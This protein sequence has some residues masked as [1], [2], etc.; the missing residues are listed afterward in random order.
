MTETPCN[1]SDDLVYTSFS[2]EPIIHP[3]VLNRQSRTGPYT[4][5]VAGLPKGGTS[6]VAAVLD[7][8]GLYMGPPDKGGTFED[9][10]FASLD[11]CRDAI[12]RRNRRHDAWGFKNPAGDLVVEQTLDWL[13]NPYV[14]CVFRDP[15]AIAQTWSRVQQK[16]LD[17]DLLKTVRQ[18]CDRLLDAV[19][20]VS[21]P[22]L[23][24]SVE[25]IKSHP[26]VFVSAVADFLGLHPSN[27]QWMAAVGRINVRGGYF[28]AQSEQLEPGGTP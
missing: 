22:C 2:G 25:R 14:L 28:L 7:A 5:V 18:R 15:L 10:A 13:R 27:A 1:S 26:E 12:E 11:D 3:L 21:K 20:A 4:A 17:Y 24:T 19:F 16:P 23:L 6:M 8:L 9:A